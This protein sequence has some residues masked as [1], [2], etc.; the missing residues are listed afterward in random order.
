VIC[1]RQTRS[2]IRGRSSGPLRGCP[3]L[4]L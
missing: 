2:S 3:A 1:G 4:S